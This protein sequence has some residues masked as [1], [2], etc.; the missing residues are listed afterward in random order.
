MNDILYQ[1][2]NKANTGSDKIKNIKNNKSS[3][4][5]NKYNNNAPSFKSSINYSNSNAE[6]SKDTNSKSLSSSIIRVN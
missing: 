1:N 6:I 5:S 4:C 2:Y 3:I